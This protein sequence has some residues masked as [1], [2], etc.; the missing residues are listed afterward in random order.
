VLVVGEAGRGG[1]GVRGRPPPGPPPARPAPPP[2]GDP[3]TTDA[4]LHRIAAD[5]VSVTTGAPAAR[6]RQ[7]AAHTCGTFFLDTSRAGNRKWCS[8]ASCGNRVRVAAHRNRA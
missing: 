8:S 2:G 5:A 1:G 7:C 4:I 3:G 6:L